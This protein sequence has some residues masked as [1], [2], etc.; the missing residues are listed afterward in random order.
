MRSAFA[1]GDRIQVSDEFFWAKGATG[2]ISLPPSEVI[3]ISGPWSGELTR[4]ENSAL[5]TNTVYW[6][7]FDE[8]QYVANV[9]GPYKGGCIWESALTKLAPI[10]RSSQN[11]SR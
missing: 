11:L 3:A 2:T 1:E 10:L 8:P 5:G 7:W 9:D 6:V 4:Q